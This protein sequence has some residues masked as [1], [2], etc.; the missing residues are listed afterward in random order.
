MC[1]H[2]AKDKRLIFHS[3]TVENLVKKTADAIGLT[4]M[5]ILPFVNYT[6]EHASVDLAIDLLAL[7]SMVTLLNFAFDFMATQV[8]Q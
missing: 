7:R 5:C 4:E 8:S 1:R 3:T 2:V 6:T